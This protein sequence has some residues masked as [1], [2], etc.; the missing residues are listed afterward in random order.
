[1]LKLKLRRE[2]EGTRLKGTAIELFNDAG[3]GAIQ[4]AARDFLEITYPTHDIL[5]GIEA[6]GPDQGRPIVVIGER[7]AGKSHLL[8]T[9]YH[10]AR[11]AEDVSRWLQD[12]ARKLGQPGLASIRMRSGMHVISASM[13]LQEY[14]FLW[15]LLLNN[16]PQGDYIRGKWEGMGANKTDVP[17]ASLI[18][19]L[20][21]GQPTMLLV[22]E[23]QT[24]YDGLTNSEERPWR[25][26]AFNFIQVLSEIASRK[27]DLLVLVVSVRN[28]DTDAYRQVHRN[29]P[30]QVDFKAGG[31]AE[32]VQRER[33]NML[34]H[35]LFENRPQVSAELIEQLIAPHLN[36]YLQCMAVPGSERQK[37][38][39][40]F[41]ESWPFAPHMLQLLED[42]VLVA[43]AA[44]DTRDL[45]R[46]L[47]NLFKSR[48]EAVPMLTAADFRLDDDGSGIGALLD[49]VSNQRHRELR[50]R[51]QRN[52]MAVMEAVPRHAVDLPHLDDVMA[53][54]WLRSIAVGNKAGAEHG[55]L[56]VD[57]TRDRQIDDNL[58]RIELGTIFENSFNIHEEGSRL[59]LKQEENAQTK[60]MATARND[61]QFT[62]GADLAHLAKEIRYVLAGSGDVP[63][64]FRVIVLCRDW[65]TEPWKWLAEEEKPSRW[66]DRTPILVLPEEPDA[67]SERLAR[68]LKEQLDERRNCV[69][70]LI[71][72]SRKNLYED[73]DL[74]VLARAVMKSE[75][76]SGQS[77]EY[78]A[79][80]RKYQTELRDI[81][82]IRFNRFAVIER[83]SFTDP[84]RSSFHVEY[85]GKAGAEIPERIKQICAM[86][87]WVQEDFDEC[88]MAAA[89]NNDSMGKVLKELR[90][91]RAES[92]PCIPWLGEAEMKERV[93]KLCARGMIAINV[94]GSNLLQARPGEDPDAAWRRM[95]SSLGYS[96]RQ[97]DEVILYL[98]SASPTTGGASKENT[99]IPPDAPGEPS[100]G[101]PS[102]GLWDVPGSPRG[103]GGAIPPVREPNRK[104]SRTRQSTSALNHI[105]QL[106]TWGIGP[107]TSVSEITLRISSATGA[108][109]K[110]MLKKM[111]ETLAFELSLEQEEP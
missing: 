51:A 84:A 76:W 20:L 6:I 17:P 57:A 72:S 22:D 53:S 102:G 39:A 15:D 66:D 87:L 96:G 47:A 37:T 36:A 62:D 28:G 49:S 77:P 105:G 81:L 29:N 44:Q 56:Q 10:A 74:I 104:I 103:G 23:L 78:R 33:R 60:L 2:F 55:M 92:G 69:R 68:F 79:I 61:R 70:F 94:R 26:W 99:G 35:R 73:R 97:L 65:A 5:K 3:S 63:K 108:Q 95:R 59:L 58:F 86:D 93:G 82:K 16:H 52:V 75:E 14:T 88:V 8:A 34:L 45:I 48:G 98:P 4:V 67:M 89:R 64:D 91:P 27:P 71:P 40:L 24:W 12:W 54:L 11:S 110:D 32:R 21:A 13:H 41:I 18:E 90:E 1:M 106:E 19:E 9:L 100:P 25:Q 30:V 46:I 43:T 109:L 111:P 7:G 50:E 38:A 42:Q 83:W 85:L 101:A 31:D 80:H 107:A